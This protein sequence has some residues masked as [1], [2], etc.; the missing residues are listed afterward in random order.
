MLP[1]FAWT[2]GRVADPGIGYL[3][4]WPLSA[5]AGVCGVTA[6]LGYGRRLE[7]VGGAW[8]GYLRESALPVYVLHQAGIVVIAYWLVHLS[9]PLAARWLVLMVA[10]LATPLAIY[11]ALVRPFPVVRAAFGMRAG[12]GRTSAAAVAPLSTPARP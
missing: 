3:L 1:P 10:A 7:T 9:L 8:F 12:N 11:H 2:D 5:T 4:Y 6:L